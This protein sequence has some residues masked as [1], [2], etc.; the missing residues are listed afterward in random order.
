M[1]KWL[2]SYKT[3]KQLKAEIEELEIKLSE[4]KDIARKLCSP[5]WLEQDYHIHPLR[6]SRIIA[7]YFSGLHVGDNDII[8]ITKKNMLVDFVDFANECEL[9]EW[10]IEED[11]D[12][13]IHLEGTLRVVKYRGD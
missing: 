11:T 13:A 3:R 4:M 5:R 6:C 1:F 9:I 2:K 8:S 7:P 10:D 12:G